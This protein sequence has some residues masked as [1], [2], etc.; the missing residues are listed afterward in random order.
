M[1]QELLIGDSVLYYY[2]RSGLVSFN[3]S[4]YMPDCSFYCNSTTNLLGMIAKQTSDKR[5]QCKWQP[6]DKGCFVYSGPH[7]SAILKRTHLLSTSDIAKFFSHFDVHQRD[8]EVYRARVFALSRDTLNPSI[9]KIQKK[10]RQWIKQK[11][12]SLLPYLGHLFPSDVLACIASN[13]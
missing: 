4:L 7:F 13:L 10:F 5:F 9:L 8:T 1:P 3:G 2:P 11:R 6:S 12:L